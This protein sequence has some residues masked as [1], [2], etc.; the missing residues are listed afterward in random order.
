MTEEDSDNENDTPD[1]PLED[2]IESP[3]VEAPSDTSHSIAPEIRF[4]AMAGR[5]SSL[6]RSDPTIASVI[7]D[8]ASS[9]LGDGCRLGSSD[10]DNELARQC[11]SAFDEIIG[12]HSA[13]CLQVGG[14]E[15]H[16]APDTAIESAIW[17]ARCKGDDDRFK[18]IS[19]IGSDHGR[20]TLTRTLSGR[21]ELHQG[22]GPMV[23]G[24]QYCPSGD[25]DAVRATIDDSTAAVLISVCDLHDGCRLLDEGYLLELS[26][27][28]HQQ[29]VPL[30]V[31]ETRLSFAATCTPFAF[32]AIAEVPVDAVVLSAGLF[33]GLAGGVLIGS[34]EFFA[35]GA[36]QNTPDGSE[37]SFPHETNLRFLPGTLL[38]ARLATATI[39]R[40]NELAIWSHAESTAQFAADLAHSIGGFE[41]V[42]DMNVLGATI[43]IE[44][45]I[46][47]DEMV[48][49]MA[50]QGIRVE[51]A[52]ETALRL[53]L[54]VVFATA[55]D[56]GSS[57]RD[58][59]I[60]L[61]KTGLETIERQ[62]IDL[63]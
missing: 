28:C 44:T 52:G 30:I 5:V 40:L 25:I 4:D 54:P 58:E 10:L 43:G 46:P 56:G 11:F 34:Q 8:S 20:S 63:G 32:Q 24:I 22:F 49:A 23:P 12:E 2:T 21:P 15:I 18:I 16:A 62:T 9:D 6:E 53:Q 45:D 29:Q 1:H 14:I 17:T 35:G 60:E 37:S 38:Q 42:R 48:Q 55:V 61:M 50:G 41:F 7:Q 31:D 47:A 36:N 39:T 19:L 59:S 26:D 51:A 57:Q 3:I 13:D 33:G 27:L